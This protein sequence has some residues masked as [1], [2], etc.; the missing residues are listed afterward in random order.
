MRGE[1]D[2]LLPPQ[3]V[4]SRPANLIEAEVAWRLIRGPTCNLLH[5]LKIP[6]CE[7]EPTAVDLEAMRAMLVVREV[8][9]RVEV[10][11]NQDMERK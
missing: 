6:T 11:A 10:E 9:H 2:F 7:Q 8:E 1:I 3:Q 4:V 5:T